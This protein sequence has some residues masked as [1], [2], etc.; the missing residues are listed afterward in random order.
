MLNLIHT[1]KQWYKTQLQIYNR[2]A[3]KHKN[4]GAPINDPLDAEIGL[5]VSG[6]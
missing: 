2:L 3:E 1:C 5:N 4:Q 6:H